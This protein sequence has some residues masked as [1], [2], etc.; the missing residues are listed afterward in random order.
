VKLIIVLNFEELVVLLQILKH[1]I[2]P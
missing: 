1:F 2:S